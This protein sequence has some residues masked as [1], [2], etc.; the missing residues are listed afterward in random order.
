MTRMIVIFMTLLSLFFMPLSTSAI[1]RT[2]AAIASL[3]QQIQ[4]ISLVENKAVFSHY[5]QSLSSDGEQSQQRLSAAEFDEITSA[6]ADF[7][8]QRGIA[9]RD[10]NGIHDPDLFTAAMAVEPEIEGYLELNNRIRYLM[11]LASRHQWHP[12]EFVSLLE[13]GKSDPSIPEIIERLMWLRDYTAEYDSAASTEIQ[14]YDDALKDAVMHFQWRHGLKQDGIIGPKTLNWLNRTPMDRAK[15]LAFNFIERAQYM[16][17]IGTRYLLINIPA[18]EM[19]LVNDDQ[20]ALRS[21]VIVGKPYRQTPVF[22]GEISNLVLNPSWTVPRKLVKY[23]LL[24]KV[25]QDGSYLHRF[26]FQAFNY[27]GE[28]VTKTADEWR[29]VAKGQ[30][31]YRLVQKPGVGNTLGRY[32]FF[33]VNPYSVYL[34]DTTEKKLFDQDDRALSSGCIRIEKV[35]QLASWMASYLVSDKQTWVDMQY[36]RNRTQWFAFDNKL[37]IHLVYWTSWLDSQN[38]AQFRDDIYNRNQNITS[39]FHASN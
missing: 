17:N 11:W 36:E 8:L 5:Q 25:R 12:I 21:K 37:P 38:I 28:L 3:L 1:A 15:L 2:D 10:K 6:I 18:Y 19:V 31:P 26:N 24:P 22:K 35:E 14:L 29:D 30:F 4:L 9:I 16:A 39:Q 13:P 34:H 33:F 32:K 20:V 23:D 7:W 27:D